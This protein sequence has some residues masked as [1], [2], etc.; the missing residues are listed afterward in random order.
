MLLMVVVVLMVVV[1]TRLLLLLCHWT[2]ADGSVCFAARRRCLPHV[3][4]W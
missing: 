4:G 1:L 3:R 2:S